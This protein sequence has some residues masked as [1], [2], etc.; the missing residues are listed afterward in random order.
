MII[1]DEVTHQTLGCTEILSLRIR[2]SH[3]Y[4]WCGEAFGTQIAFRNIDDT[5]SVQHEKLSRRRPKQFGLE[6]STQMHHAAAC[7]NRSF[8]VHES[9]SDGSTWIGE[10]WFL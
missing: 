9:Q 5:A 2:N 4:C 6:Y 10:Q 1:K 8:T 7:S 3:W